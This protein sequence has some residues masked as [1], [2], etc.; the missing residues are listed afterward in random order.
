MAAVPS[1]NRGGT[2]GVE[3]LSVVLSSI[4]YGVTCIQTFHYFRSARARSDVWWIKP[5]VLAL[6][7][8]D[9][10]HEAFVI[11]VPYHY[12]VTHYGE[13]EVLLENVWSMPFTIGVTAAITFITNSFFVY[14]IWKL[15]SNASVSLFC[16]VGAVSESAGILTYCFKFYLKKNLL[17]AEES[18]K[19]TGLVVISVAVAANLVISATMIFYLNASRTGLRRSDSVITKLIVLV[20]STGTSTTVA[21]I[22]D[23]IAYIAAPDLLYVLLFKFMIAKLSVNSTLTSLNLREH[24]NNMLMDNSANSIHL[25]KIGDDSSSAPISERA[26]V[27]NLSPSMKTGPIEFRDKLQVSY[28]FNGSDV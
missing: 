6:L 24:I 10:I 19:T 13:P 23:L 15:G 20:I 5:M 2:I 17:D 9:T 8:F 3:Y 18:L 25:S 14:R 16:F 26:Q 1:F 27:L 11:H 21:Y 28:S 22:A 4:L 7:T 12:L